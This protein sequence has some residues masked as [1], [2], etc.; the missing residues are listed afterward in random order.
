MSLEKIKS[1]SAKEPDFEKRMQ[2]EYISPI[3]DSLLKIEEAI[4]DLDS[5][6]E[7]KDFLSQA[8]YDYDEMPE[9]AMSEADL[10]EH[11]NV[12][13]SLVKE[14]LQSGLSNDQKE[15]LIRQKLPR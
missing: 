10:A 6:E 2:D 7:L 15:E 5:R 1:I 12:I 9:H 11:K 3:I 4:V 8:R 13:E 14:V